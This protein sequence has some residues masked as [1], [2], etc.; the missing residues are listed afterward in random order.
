MVFFV[1]VKENTVRFLEKFGKFQKV[2]KP[3]LHFYV[4][5]VY[6]PTRVVSL[7]EHISECEQHKAITKNNVEI[8]VDGNFFYKVTDPNKAFYNAQNY[9]SAI[10]GLSNSVS[11]AEIGR[12]FLDEIFQN[13]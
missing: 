6:N 1:V 4:P 9:V 5:L 8:D 2:L 10:E 12:M 7:K 11:R 3:G 13:R